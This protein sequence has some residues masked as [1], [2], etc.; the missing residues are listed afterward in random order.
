MAV[1]SGLSRKCA[2][3]VVWSFTTHKC[4]LQDQETSKKEVVKTHNQVV[5]PRNNN[6]YI[7]DL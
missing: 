5:E 1:K 3:S 2:D 4:T 7:Q 6:N